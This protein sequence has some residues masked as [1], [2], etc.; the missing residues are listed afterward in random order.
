MI[1]G[2]EWC[3]GVILYGAK[4]KAYDFVPGYVKEQLQDY[5]EPKR[6]ICYMDRTLCPDPFHD[7]EDYLNEVFSEHSAMI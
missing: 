5:L 1:T 3:Y 4:E 7:G 2:Q 6:G